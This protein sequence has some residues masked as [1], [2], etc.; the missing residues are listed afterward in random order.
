MDPS[1]T[2]AWLLYVV[3]WHAPHVPAALGSGDAPVHAA[4]ATG[5][6]A[7]AGAAERPVSGRAEL[8]FVSTTGNTSTETIGTAAELAFVPGPWRLESQGR[9]IRT[10]AEDHV[11]A[12]SISSQLRAS[13]RLFNEVAGYGEARFLRNAFAGIRRQTTLELGLA[14]E[15]LRRGAQLVATE[16]A[17]G[18]IDEDRLSGADRRLTSGTV[19]LKLG[20]PLSRSSSWNQHARVTTDLG[21]ADDWRIR[22]EASIAASLNSILSLKL[23]HALTYVNE[24]VPGFGNT[25]AMGAAALVAKF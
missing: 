20:F 1:S 19:G 6:N 3:L 10:T 11:L 15:F 25:D 5:G 12:E 22:H 23:S 18:H 24:P 4:P 7:P 14:K 17:V 21:N 13:R 2:C 16:A 8:S 9:Y